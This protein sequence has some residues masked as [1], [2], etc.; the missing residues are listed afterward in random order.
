MDTQKSLC[1]YFD[2]YGRMAE[3]VDARDSKSRMG[4]H[5]RVRFPLWPPR[6]SK[7]S[8]LLGLGSTAG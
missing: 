1:Y 3:L 8:D 7:K 6:S 5:V 4:N 2:A